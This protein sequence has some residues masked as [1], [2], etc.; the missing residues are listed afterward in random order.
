LQFV[1]SPNLQSDWE[2]VR[3][4]A[5]QG[6]VLGLLLFN[7]Y[8][9]DFPCI[10]NYVSHS[11]LFADDTDILVFASDHNELNSKLNSVLHC[12]AKWFQSNQL[13]HAYYTFYTTIELLLSLKI[14]NR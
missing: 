14:S 12:I 4:G 5:P 8:I 3:R 9:N 1:D 6:S 13:V 2:L 11:L 10:I 7:V